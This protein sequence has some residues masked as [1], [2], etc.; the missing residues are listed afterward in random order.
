MTNRF[1]RL[2]LIAGLATVTVGAGR[3]AVAQTTGGGQ[4]GRAHV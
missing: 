4:I 1:L 2:A 3:L